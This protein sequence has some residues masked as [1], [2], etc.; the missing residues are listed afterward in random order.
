MLTSESGPDRL[1]RGLVAVLNHRLTHLFGIAL[2]FAVGG[3]LFMDWIAMPLY[4]RHN[5]EY[6]M[7]NITKMRYEDALLPLEVGDF[8]LIKE[9]ERYSDQ[10]P[11]GY[12]IEQSPPSHT[13][14]K[15]GRRVYV[16]VSRGERRVL[17]P[18]LLERSQRD[19]ELILSG[20]RLAL[21]D[22]VFQYSGIHPDGVVIG[23]SVPPNAE[24]AVNTRVNLIVS[25]GTE[26]SV[27][28]VPAVE[29]RTF[30]DALQHLKRA[31]L[32]IGQIT[33]TVAPDL[34]PE[35]VIHQSI[36]VNT[37]VEKGRSI[38]LEISRLA[39]EGNGKQ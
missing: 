19:A 24:V 9:E 2:T 30:S 25:M 31:G 36:P 17:M 16:V 37:Q 22:V 39:S 28:I 12:I 4:T 1:R 29:G 20:Q 27:F 32:Q 26:P 15:S 33:Y 6:E 18:T 14:V 3:V 11:S 13:K 35:T 10:L 5:E 7:P 38:D 34:L 8:V 21:G 23:Q